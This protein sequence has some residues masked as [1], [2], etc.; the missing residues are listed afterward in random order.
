MAVKTKARHIIEELGEHL[1][2]SIFSVVLALIILGLLTYTALISGTESRLPHA[3]E[4]LFHIFHPVHMLLSAAA[5]TAMFWR[6]EKKV[7][8]ALIIGFTGAVVVCG[9]SDIV[10]PFLGGMLLGA[11]MHLHICIID[12]P[13]I[14]V[15]FVIVGILAGF[16][17]PAA[18]EKSTQYSHA[19]HVA[20]SSMASILYL[21]AFGLT[22]W[23]D[24]IGSVLVI[25]IL[26]VMV[27]CCI[28]DIVYPLLM[29]DEKTSAH[30][31][32]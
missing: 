8:K 26:A 29:V 13:Q 28:S 12:D 17:A 3:S 32:E 20:T 5:T 2:Y 22:N 21:A 18:I 9:L 23:M 27:P 1:P 10:F 14:V 16:M 11:K 19:M 4:E 30:Q 15:P 24:Y 31:K 6:H 25:V 7:I